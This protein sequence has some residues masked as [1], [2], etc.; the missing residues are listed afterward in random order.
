MPESFVTLPATR[1]GCHTPPQSH[2]FRPSRIPPTQ[3]ATWDEGEAAHYRRK[4]TLKKIPV[5]GRR[6][7]SG[8]VGNDVHLVKQIIECRSRLSFYYRENA[9]LDTALNAH[10]LHKS[11]TRLFPS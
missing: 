8:S 5:D 9:G 3:Y 1:Q 6:R 11:L 4:D 7:G 2:R 10:T